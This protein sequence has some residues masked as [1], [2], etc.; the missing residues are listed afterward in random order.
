MRMQINFNELKSMKQQDPP[1]GKRDLSLFSLLVE[2][3]AEEEF[4]REWG[5]EKQAKIK[6]H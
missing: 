5:K 2:W 3:M 6:I 1:K 4:T